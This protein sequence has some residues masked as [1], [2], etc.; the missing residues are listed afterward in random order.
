MARVKTP[1]TFHPVHLGVIS[2]KTLSSVLQSAAQE[3]LLG[4]AAIDV[5]IAGGL[6]SQSRRHV[7]LNYWFVWLLAG[8]LWQNGGKKTKKKK[9]TKRFCR[10][11][12]WKNGV[13]TGDNSTERAA[14]CVDTS[15]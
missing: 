13:V 5:L 9:K 11:A 12:V 1:P 15:F 3:S 2:P 10:P 4:P 6:L 8:Q 7:P 14:T